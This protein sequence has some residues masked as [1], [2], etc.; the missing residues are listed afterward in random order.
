MFTACPVQLITA[1]PR[2]ESMNP[3]LPL[4]RYSYM[5]VT[6][7]YPTPPGSMSHSRIPH[8]TYGLIRLFS[9]GPPLFNWMG[10]LWPRPAV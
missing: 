4:I 3:T 8:M 7:G 5:Y 2:L 1:V 6:A 10:S 9:L